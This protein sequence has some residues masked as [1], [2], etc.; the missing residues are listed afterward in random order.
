M[1]RPV[2]AISSRVSLKRIIHRIAGRDS[3]PPGLRGSR[4][5]LPADRGRE[6][7]VVL[8]RPEARTKP[9]ASHGGF[10]RRPLSPE[11]GGALVTSAAQPAAPSQQLT[12]PLQKV[13]RENR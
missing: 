12:M 9:A 3:V 7:A 2:M 11:A 8:S 10:S 1:G 6:Q 13:Q 4:Y 5:Q